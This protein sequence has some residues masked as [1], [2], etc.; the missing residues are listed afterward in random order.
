MKETHIRQAIAIL[1]ANGY[2]VTK[3]K[4]KHEIVYP[5]DTERF[6]SAW[7]LWRMYRHEIN[8][9]YKSCISEQAALKKLSSFSEDDAI[10]MLNQSIENSWQGIFELKNNNNANGTNTYKGSEQVQRRD[11]LERLRQATGSLL[12]TSQQEFFGDF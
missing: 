1:K 12:N 8:K 10:A 3:K 9:P 7:E 11:G 6:K 4:Q 2:S 5:F